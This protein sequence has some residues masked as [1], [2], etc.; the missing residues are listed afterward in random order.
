MCSVCLCAWVSEWGGVGGPTYERERETMTEK[1]KERHSAKR[2]YIETH[3][4]T[5]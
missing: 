3:K 1:E 5:S 2:H 4:S